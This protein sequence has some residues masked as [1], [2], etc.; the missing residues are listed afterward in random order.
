MWKTSHFISVTEEKAFTYTQPRRTVIA[1][2]VNLCTKPSFPPQT[3]VEAFYN[4]LQEE[5]KHSCEETIVHCLTSLDVHCS[6]TS[7][8]RVKECDEHPFLLTSFLTMTLK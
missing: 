8:D 7:T 5:G 6:S 1:A 3:F 2:F 4:L